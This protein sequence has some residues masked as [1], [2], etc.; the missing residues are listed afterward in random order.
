MAIGNEEVKVAQ[1]LKDVMVLVK[2]IVKCVKD[3]KDYSGLI[4]DLVKAV[5]GADEIPE[6]FKADLEACINTVTL[7][8]IAIAMLFVKKEEVAVEA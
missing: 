3:K 7:E 2:E 8:S 4:D 1:E 5:S 6:E